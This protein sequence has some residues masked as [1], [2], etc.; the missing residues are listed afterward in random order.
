M[1]RDIHKNVIDPFLDVS[2]NEYEEGG[3]AVRLNR[4]GTSSFA[5]RDRQAEAPVNRKT[6]LRFTELYEPKE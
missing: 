5:I 3:H 4:S 2:E 1:D 6:R